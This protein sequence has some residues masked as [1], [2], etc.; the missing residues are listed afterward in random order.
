MAL[1]TRQIAR[2]MP[3]RYSDGSGLYLEVKPSGARSWLLRYERQGR[4]RW[5][6]L[7]PFPLIGLAQARDRA[8]KAKLQLLDGIDPLDARR[9]EKAANEIA[10]A[11][12]VTFKEAALDFLKSP[13]I[14]SL[15]NGK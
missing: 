11:H 9:A 13:K 12:Q 1:N 5:M 10:S 3:G 2:V 8:R 15:K 6:G 4:E 7:G 14:Q